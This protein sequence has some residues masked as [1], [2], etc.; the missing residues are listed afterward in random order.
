MSE[1]K[2][3]QRSVIE[4]FVDRLEAR[5]KTRLGEELKPKDKA[6][7]A[8]LRR[9]AGKTLDQCRAQATV[10]FFETDPPSFRLGPNG[11]DDGYE[12]AFLVTTLYCLTNGRGGGRLA[13]EMRLLA[14]ENDKEDAL[15]RRLV[16][17]LDCQQFERLA[18]HLRH[19][20]KL[21]NSSGRGLNWYQ[22]MKD[23][24]Y[25]HHPDRPVQRRWANDFARVPKP[26]DSS[27]N[28]KGSQDAI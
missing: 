16:R 19:T 1:T 8:I 17:L 18:Y 22:L 26:Q 15:K 10:T 23:L 21:L 12:T 25:W 2:T 28:E 6:D 3:E 13:Q 27:D 4:K 7:R 5:F 24:S 9:C 14:R 11:G 20:V